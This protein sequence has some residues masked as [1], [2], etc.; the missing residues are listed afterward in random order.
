MHR[1]PAHRP[2]HPRPR[3]CCNSAMKETKYAGTLEPV[4]YR[5]A[6][7]YVVHRYQ[8][9][10]PKTN[11]QNKSVQKEARSSSANQKSTAASCPTE[12][13]VVIN[14]WT[15]KSI[16]F[17]PGAS[18][19]AAR[20]AVGPSGQPDNERRQEQ[21]QHQ[22]WNRMTFEKGHHHQELLFR[23]TDYRRTTYFK[24]VARP[25]CP[26]GKLR[27][28]V[29]FSLLKPPRND[30]QIVSALTHDDMEV[31]VVHRL[32]PLHSVVYHHSEPFVETLVDQKVDLVAK[33][34]CRREGS[35]L[36]EG[37]SLG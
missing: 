32:A 19:A 26:I 25:C 22:Y 2:P 1:P 30:S 20:P 10:T 24:S 37:H 14:F 7:E 6:H 33:T 36:L 35:W 34:L 16:N 31:K 11:R 21:E 18:S 8:R 17:T 23:L 4:R 29:S 28:Q 12:P 27:A 9:T 13:V 3:R 15:G 5:R